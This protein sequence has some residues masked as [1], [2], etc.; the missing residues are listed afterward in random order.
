MEDR[1]QNVDRRAAT[2]GLDLVAA[3]CTVLALLL[4]SRITTP[5]RTVLCF[6]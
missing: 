6:A 4:G 1:H 2:G 5:K 3:V